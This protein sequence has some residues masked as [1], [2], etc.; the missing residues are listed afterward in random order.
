MH[1]LSV[2]E[3]TK[4][5][6]GAA[7]SVSMSACADTLLSIEFKLQQSENYYAYKLE[8]GKAITANPGAFISKK[9]LAK[10]L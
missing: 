5:N 2:A 10:Q 6:G 1:E 8:A 9:V 4:G 3:L 7:N